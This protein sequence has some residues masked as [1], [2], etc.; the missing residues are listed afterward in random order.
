MLCH[1][2]FLDSV[3]ICIPYIQV[4]SREKI[5]LTLKGLLPSLTF[6]LKSTKD[7]DKNQNYTTNM[8]ID[9]C[10]SVQ[11]TQKLP[12]QGYVA[13][14]LEYALNTS[15]VVITKLLTVTKYPLFKWEWIFSPLCRCFPST[16]T[17]LAMSNRAGIL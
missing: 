4:S 1:S 6:T 9:H 17:I 3:I 2:T 16:V 5:L 11:L 13:H 14:K 8:I 7:A 12:K 15:T 10:S